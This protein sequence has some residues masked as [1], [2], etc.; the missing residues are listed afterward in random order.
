MNWDEVEIKANVRLRFLRD[1]HLPLQIGHL[2]CPC[3]VEGFPTENLWDVRIMINSNFIK[4][5]EIIET[6]ICFLSSDVAEKYLKN[7]AKIILTEGGNDLAKG[8]IIEL[9]F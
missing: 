8:E 3:K 9:L 7:G 2:G 6:K 5:D 4:K 1:R